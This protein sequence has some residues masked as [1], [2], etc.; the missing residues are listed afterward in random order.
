M[1]T[2]IEARRN[3][4][5]AIPQ[6][7]RTLAKSI[8]QYI[9]PETTADLFQ[10]LLDGLKDYSSDERGDVGSWIRV[11]CVRGLT[12]VSEVLIRHA[13]DLPDFEAYLSPH[14]YHAAIAGILKQGVERLDNVRQDAGACFLRLLRLSPPDVSSCDQWQI[15]GHELLERLFPSNKAD[16]SWGDGN[17]LFPKAVQFVQIERYRDS[18]LQGLVLSIGSK[19]DS[20]HRPLSASLVAY[21]NTIHVTVSDGPTYSLQ[22]LVT[23]LLNYARSNLAANAVV[24]PVL[25]AFNVLFEGGV[26]KRLDEYPE[27]IETLQDLL[28]VCLSN[29]SRIKSI[30]RISQCMKITVHLL[31]FEN[32]FSRAVSEL[33]SFLNHRFPHV[34]SET[35]EYLYIFLQ[36]HNVGRET[37]E[38]EELLLETE[39]LTEDTSV[40]HDAAQATV[41]AFENAERVD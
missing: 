4:F 8:S 20:I 40:A 15:S 1:K 30:H 17:F 25:Q 2:N 13:K 19:T 11:A 24:L 35:A 41:S 31:A 38:V 3:C 29:I 33:T 12:E 32:L 37:D 5:E 16:E 10:V 23:D 6:I 39:W 26:L 34:R 36:S 27:G 9:S 18:V 14:R 21:C 22:R 28:R 7:Y